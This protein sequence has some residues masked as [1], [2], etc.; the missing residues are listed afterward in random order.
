MGQ[1]KR[2]LTYARTDSTDLAVAARVGAHAFRIFDEIIDYTRVLRYSCVYTQYFFPVLN[3]VYCTVPRV[4][5]IYPRR[6]HMR[7]DRI[8]ARRIVW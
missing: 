7:L 6:S 1:Q 3:L 5:I 4:F 8:S 2:L